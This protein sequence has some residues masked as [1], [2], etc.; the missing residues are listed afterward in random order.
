MF[1]LF[2]KSARHRRQ[3]A[4]AG[5]M[6][7]GVLS[8]ASFPTLFLNEGRAVKTA[9]SLQ[10]G[11]ASVV[12]VD[13]DQVDSTCEGK[14][15][16]LSGEART[17]EM[18]TDDVF[19]VEVNAIRLTRSV[20]MYQWKEL[21]EK[22]TRKVDGKS[23]TETRF[24][25]E[26]IWADSHLD[27]SKYHE[28]SGHENPANFPFEPRSIEAKQVDIGAYQLSQSLIAKIDQ[29][30]SLSVDLSKVPSTLASNLRP[31]GGVQSSATGFYWMHSSVSKPEV[32]TGTSAEAN[33]VQD[34]VA[35]DKAVAAADE[36]QIGDTRIHFAVTRPTEVS[37]MAQQT[38]S[39][40]EPFKTHSGRSLNMLSSGVV[41]AAAMIEQ[42]ETENKILTWMLR[43]AGT[44]M[45]VF[46]IGLVIRP[47]SSMTESIPLVGSLVNMGATLVA[48]LLGGA[49]ALMT[50]AVAWL[51][52]RPLIAI[53]LI[54]ISC[55]VMYYLFKQASKSQVEVVSAS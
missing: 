43:I 44:A 24:A 20:E 47:L 4:V 26:K 19:G 46:G 49:M 5:A 22:V 50:I 32:Q 11:A 55:A 23:E 25:Y 36:P 31:D 33:S 51:F 2:G 16:H 35:A 9:R 41:S 8:I 21:E 14:F 45:I 52:Y 3:S 48:V 7:G 29:A 13:S 27:S 42:A 17:D 37:V 53:P 34:Q 15:V 12:S 38:G 28:P 39:S 6:L 10:E 54:V 30:E 18:L 40:F 1:N